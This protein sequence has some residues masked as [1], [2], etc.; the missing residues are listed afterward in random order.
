LF[1][2]ILPIALLLFMYLFS[3]SGNE[4]PI[5]EDDVYQYLLKNNKISHL[6]ISVVTLDGTS[7]SGTLLGIGNV[8]VIKDDNNVTYYIHWPEISYIGMKQQK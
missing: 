2:P 8:M 6:N 5:F 4:A 1:I 3:Y 7:I